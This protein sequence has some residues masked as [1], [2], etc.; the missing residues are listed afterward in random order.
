MNYLKQLEQVDSDIGAMG[1][2][3]MCIPLIHAAAFE[4]MISNITLIRSPISYR[5]IVMND[6]YNI[7]LVFNDAGYWHHW[8]ID[9]SWGVAGALTAYDL[10]DLIGCLAPRK[11]VLAEIQNQLLEPASEKVIELDMAFPK[12]VYKAMDVIQNIKITSSNEET[13]SLVDWCFK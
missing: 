7:G 12:K 3:E 1:I 2:G 10:P 13:G 8:E 4:P 5:S 9:Y 11:V 6:L